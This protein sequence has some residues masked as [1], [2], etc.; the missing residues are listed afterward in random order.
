MKKILSFYTNTPL[1][2]RIAIGLAIGIVLGLTV[3]QVP[4][5]ALLGSLFVGALKAIAPVLVFVLVI[6]SLASAG[7]GGQLP[8][9]GDHS[10]VCLR[11]AGR[12]CRSQRG[13]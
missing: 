3:P 4:V 5:V 13:V 7:C 10:P 2:L 11:G 1:I 6:A 8:V 12:P 9:P